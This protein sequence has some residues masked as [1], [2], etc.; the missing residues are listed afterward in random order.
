[1]AHEF[2]LI[3]ML[4]VE[5]QLKLNLV[6]NIVNGNAPTYLSPPFE[7]TRNRHNINTRSSTMSFQVPNVKSFGKTSFS[8]TGIL[9][10]NF[11]PIQIQG[12]INRSQFK[13]LVKT[14]LFNHLNNSE[15]NSYIYY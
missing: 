15:A 3:G 1:M 10:W 12:A 6:Y 4:P 2:G 11:L 9:D 14:F 13:R 8:Y 5:L 7:L